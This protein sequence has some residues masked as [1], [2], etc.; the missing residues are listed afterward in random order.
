ME[1]KSFESKGRN[2]PEI[3][4]SGAIRLPHRMDPVAY[5]HRDVV[6]KAYVDDV[7][8]G[9]I[10]WALRAGWLTNGLIKRRQS[11]TPIGTGWGG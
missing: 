10:F 2:Q 9:L 6:V 7:V 11:F 5:A 8:D 1:K 4:F 3:W